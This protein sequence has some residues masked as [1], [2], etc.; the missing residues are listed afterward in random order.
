M[1]NIIKTKCFYDLYAM[2]REEEWKEEER[3]WEELD[4]MTKEH[5]EAEAE[6]EAEAE[7]NLSPAERKAR[8]KRQRRIEK[9]SITKESAEAFEHTKEDYCKEDTFKEMVLD[10]IF[11]GEEWIH[12]KAIPG[13][14]RR[15]RP[16]FRC[17]KLKIIVEY[18]GY[19]HY[20]QAATIMADIEKKKMYE[21]M[22]YMVVEW[23]YWVQ[24]DMYTVPA[25]FLQTGKNFKQH[26]CDFHQG[27][28]TKKCVLPA[29]FCSLGRTRFE[30]ELSCLPTYTILQVL[31]SLENKEKLYGKEKVWPI[32]GLDYG[33]YYID[34]TRH[35]ARKVHTFGFEESM[36]IGEKIF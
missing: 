9:L 13:A 33:D 18:N 12:N 17:D 21:D 32:G 11:P 2:E 19:R 15:T 36:E 3:E 29:D 14:A 27:F 6:A 7:R 23:P 24:P 22:G 5:F 31:W 10:K 25:L 30:Y 8:E 4:E 20:T 1:N 26:F 28:V 35:W 16:D 34:G